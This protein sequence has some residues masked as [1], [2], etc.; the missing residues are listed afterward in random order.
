MSQKLCPG[1]NRTRDMAKSTE[2]IIWRF[3]IQSD[4]RHGVYEENCVQNLSFEIPVHEIGQ[5]SQK[6]CPG[7]KTKTMKMDRK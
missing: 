6:F 4:M 5:M 2:L 7:T 3:F 1:Q